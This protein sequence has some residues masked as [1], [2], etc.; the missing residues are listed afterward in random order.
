MKKVITLLFA[1][2]LLVG[3]SSVTMA[4]ST[5]NTT[6]NANANVVQAMVVG[7]EKANLEF[8]NVL[9]DSWKTV[10]A[11]T[12]T[13]IA[14]GGSV[15]GVTGG[16][17]RGFFSIEIV[18]GTPIDYSLAVPTNLVGPSE[19]TLPIDFN[20]AN[21]GGDATTFNG[22]LT[23]TDPSGTN[24]LSG[25]IL[26]GG[27]GSDFSSPANSPITLDDLAMPEGGKVYLVVGGTV[28]AGE[29][30]ALGSYAGTLTLT[31]TVND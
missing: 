26:T 24:D 8:N 25:A 6:I 21:L 27:A 31:A 19:A 30:Q 7:N 9:V 4:Q 23:T 22:F 20:T 1:V 11:I 16:E 13:A 18:Q 5:D 17:S 10:N 14:T 29:S 3:F 12:N 2:T 15:N 28:K